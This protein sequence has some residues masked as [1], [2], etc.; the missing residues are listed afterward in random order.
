MKKTISLTAALLLCALAYAQP[1]GRKNFNKGWFFV[2]DTDREAMIKKFDEGRGETVDLPHDWGVEG[3]FRQ[4]YP[5]ETGKLQWWGYARYGKEFRLPDGPPGEK[6]WFLE[7]DGA[8]ARPKVYCNGQ[9]AGE[10]AY[11]YSSFRTDLTPFLHEG[12]NSV[13]IEID[14]RNASSRWYPGGG[15]YRNVW[16]TE[17]APAGIAHWGTFVTSELKDG[18]AVLKIRT[19]L[20]GTAAEGKL[21]T[22]ILDKR[23]PDGKGK[24]KT[25]ATVSRNTGEI[26]DGKTVEQT[27]EIPSPELW[28]IDSPNMYTA[29][30][31]LETEGRRDVL[32]TDFGIRD[33]KWTAEGFFLNGSRLELNGVCL[34]HDAGALGA[35]WNSG[36]WERRLLMLKQMG[37]NAIRTSHNPPAPEFLDLC[38][39]LGFVV[40]DEFTDSWTIAKTP[41]GYSTMFD[42]WAEKDLTALVR[43]D[44]NHPCVIAWSIGNEVREQGDPSKFHIARE[45]GDI[46]RRE[47][48]TRPTTA[49]CDILSAAGTEWRNTIDLY[50][51]NYKPRAYA[52]FRKDNPEKP[53]YGS[54]TASTI[55][56]RGFYV[57]PVSDDKSQGKQDFQMSSYDLYAPAWATTPDTEFEGQ[58][59]NPWVAGEFVW[60]GFD[61]LGEPTPYNRDM[62]TLSN[63][64][65]ETS[66]AKAAE[67]LRELGKIS[68]PSRSSYFGIID[69]AGFPK[70]RYWIYRSR[71]RPD[72][73]SAH[74]LPHWNWKGREG[75]ITPVMVYTSGD[76]AELFVNG[77]SMGRKTKGE[78]EYRLRWDDVTYEPG[79]VKVIAYKN[80]VIW[81]EDE[82]STSGEAAKV[83]MAIESGSGPGRRFGGDRLTGDLGDRTSVK[84]EDLTDDEGNPRYFFI[85]VKI[86]DKDGVTVPDARN[87]LTFGIEGP[88]EIV[89]ADAGDATSHVPFRSHELPAFN[90]LCSVIVKADGN[91][92]RIKLR[93]E[94]EGLRPAEVV[95]TVR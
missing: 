89:A 45:L 69:L 75:E 31:E 57:F 43:R 17:A 47:D 35:A 10:W 33:A 95:I 59:R 56:S 14:N 5:G 88:G 71:W 58:D 61:Y 64:H 55:S 20:R 78:Y 3:D 60:T 66:K 72:I 52:E 84:A 22:A 54:E 91:K 34:H 2:H 41:E 19:T 26:T 92:G 16:L 79:T 50:G 11:G 65:D 74:L 27:I 36:A 8:M 28:D 82:V 62:T 76:S 53:Y 67:E 46:V 13:Y 48:P 80:G 93:A 68:V 63:F 39:R 85:D 77:K 51:F 15:I 18:K 38:D 30:S 6:A 83:E 25:L 49:G 37:C 1:E 21:T 9:P 4:E 73:P 81:A 29:V 24:S 70:D 12:I 87:L 94:S 23:S 40:L 7:I 86:S 32:Y 44:R 90:G 42:E